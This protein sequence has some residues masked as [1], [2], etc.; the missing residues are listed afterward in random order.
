MCEYVCV[1]CPNPNESIN[2]TF[3]KSPGFD[4]KEKKPLKSAG[5][6]IPNVNVLPWAFAV[7]LLKSK[8]FKSKDILEVFSKF[9][10]E[11][12]FSI[13]CESCPKYTNVQLLWRAWKSLIP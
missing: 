11:K 6:N 5:N 12:Y 9:L 4:Q 1:F 2:I 7:L 3:S 13:L 8:E 10:K